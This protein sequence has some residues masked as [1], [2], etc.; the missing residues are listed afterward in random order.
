VQGLGADK[1]V[2]Y[3]AHPQLAH[4]FA[5][6]EAPFDMILDTVGGDTLEQCCS[7]VLIRDGGRIVSVA[8]PL[9]E[10][11]QKALG[12]EERGVQCSFFVVRP[13][14]TQLAKVAALAE[15]GAVKGVVQEVFSLE[16]GAEAME[17]VESGR[18]RGK[19]VLRVD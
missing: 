7:P 19:V 12:L 15:A 3:T 11:R 13:D 14:G 9:S 17:L 10:A 16:R 5:V 8:M 18:V 4:G 2:D 1:V 6:D